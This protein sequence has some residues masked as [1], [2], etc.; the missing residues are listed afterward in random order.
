MTGRVVVL[1]GGVGGAKL[2]EGLMHIVPSGALT[3][4]VNTGDDFRHLGLHVSPDIDTLLY[5]LSGK[6]NREQ[7][8]GRAGESWAFMAALRELGGEDWFALGDGDVALHVWRTQRL[9]QGEPLSA[10]MREVAARWGVQPAVLPMTDDTIATR[11]FTDAGDLAF[12]DYFVRLRCEPRAER[13]SFQGAEAAIPAPGVI[14]AIDAADAILIAPSNPYLSVDPILAVPG[15]AKAL[16][17]ARAPV[18][19]VS[20]IVGGTSVKGPTAKLMRELG[21]PIDNEA[22]ARHYGAML[23]GLLVHGDDAAPGWLA[24]GRTDTLM[25]ETGDRIRVAAAALELAGSIGAGA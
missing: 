5:T 15:I 6:A 12:Q 4:I 13:I 11:L 16:R 23:D 2:V 20:P 9:S 8:W 21:V 7:G 14:A 24:I 18:V 1:T 10:I 22:I 19:A 25:P 17:D 3:A